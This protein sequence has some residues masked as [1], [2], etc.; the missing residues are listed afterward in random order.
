MAQAFVNGK[1][2][3]GKVEVSLKPTCPYCRRTQ[4]LLS[5]L[6]FKQGHL[7]FVHIIATGDSNKIQDYL[8]QLMGARMVPLV[9][10]SKECVGGCTNL[11]SMHKRGEH[12]TCLKQTGALQ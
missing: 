7:E 5:L 2:Q 3:P 1:I 9:F 8:Q 4:E 12:L 10:I 11:V 6:P